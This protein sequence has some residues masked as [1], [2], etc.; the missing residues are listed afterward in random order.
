MPTF[1]VF[2]RPIPANRRP[3]LDFEKVPML[4]NAG[5]KLNDLIYGRI[6]SPYVTTKEEGELAPGSGV[7]P[8]LL[9]ALRSRRSLTEKLLKMFPEAGHSS[10]ELLRNQLPNGQILTD[11]ELARRFLPLPEPEV[12]PLWNAD[13]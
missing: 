9:F 8:G 5:R 10:D 7:R 1:G 6:L 12:L 4:G 3:P 2:F 11:E 13:P